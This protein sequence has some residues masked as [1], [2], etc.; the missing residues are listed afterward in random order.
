MIRRF[1]EAG[2]HHADLNCYNI[3]IS[4]SRLYL[5]DFDRGRLESANSRWRWKEK[6]LARLHRS[7]IKVAGAH[8]VWLSAR[9]SDLLAGYNEPDNDCLEINE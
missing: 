9:W 7:I 6:N 8:P 4:N 2:V 1:H 3:L 5:I